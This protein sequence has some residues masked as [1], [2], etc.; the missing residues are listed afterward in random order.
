MGQTPV[1]KFGAGRLTSGVFIQISSRVLSK[2][3]LRD[4]I[5]KIGFRSATE[6]LMRPR[7]RNLSSESVLMFSS[8]AASSRVRASFPRACTE[9]FEKMS[10][11]CKYLRALRL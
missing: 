4:E 5:G 1:G 6:A 9:L 2:N 3:V 10:V 11:H 8:F 7:R